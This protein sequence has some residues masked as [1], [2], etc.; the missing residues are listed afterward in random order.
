MLL[1]ALAPAPALALPRLVGASGQWAALVEGRTC[2]AA[3]RSIRAPL[4]GRQTARASLSFDAGGPRRG[5]FAA[6][7]SRAPRAGAS[8]LLTIGQQQF[9]LMSAADMAWSRGPAQEVAIIAAMR[10][11][12]EIRI[13]A[14]SPDGGRIVDRYSL[15]GAPLAID[16]AAACAATL[17]NR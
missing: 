2:E 3:A 11:S 7:L 1:I 9:L 15:D 12:G 14:R 4:K 5:Q 10:R 16:A 17:A 8:V 13:E 6:R